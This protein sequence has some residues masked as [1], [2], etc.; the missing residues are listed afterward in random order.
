MKEIDKLNRKISELN[1][2]FD[3]KN[4]KETTVFYRDMLLSKNESCTVDE[5]E[6]VFRYVTVNQEVDGRFC[7]RLRY[8]KLET[9]SPAENHDFEFQYAKA[10]NDFGVD[11]FEMI[12]FANGQWTSKIIR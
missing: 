7:E 3:K 8:M 2:R 11:N 9:I 12:Q 4:V 1:E 6:A 5:W 10:V